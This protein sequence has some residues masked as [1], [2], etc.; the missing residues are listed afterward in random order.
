MQSKMGTFNEP[1]K[2]LISLE[3][4]AI[5]L[6]VRLIIIKKIAQRLYGDTD[7]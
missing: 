7:G 1:T 6:A 5:N 2:N 4:M 3:Q